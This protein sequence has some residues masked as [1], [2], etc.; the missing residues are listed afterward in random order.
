MAQ[1]NVNGGCT[2]S[3]VV[4]VVVVVIAIIHDKRGLCVCVCACTCL[5][6]FCFSQNNRLKGVLRSKLVECGWRD[7]LKAYA[8]ELIRSRGVEN[9]TAEDLIEGLCLVVLVCVCLFGC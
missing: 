2:T 3:V 6:F 8:T 5:R 7:E 4:V 9:V 1:A